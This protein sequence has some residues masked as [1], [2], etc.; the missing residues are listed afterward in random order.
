MLQADELIGRVQAY[1]PTADV[2]L[3]K[4]AYDFSYRDAPGTDCA[5]RGIRTSST[6]ARSPASSPSCR[7]DTASV[8]AGLLHDVVE[9]TLSSVDRRREAVRRRDRHLVDGVTK[10]SQDQLHLEGGPAGRELPQDGRRDGARHPRAPREALRPRRQH[11]DARAH[12]PEAQERIARET[13]EIY[14]PLANRL[15]MQAFKSELE[16][17]S[18]K[19][20][21]PDAFTGVSAG[22]REDE[23]RARQVHRRRLQD[24][25]GT[26]RRAGLRRPTSPAARSTS[27]RSGGR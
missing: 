14:A 9:D 3:I 26:P 5:N 17:L 24:A 1:Q 15:G 2:D 6:R 11:A 25:L 20:L 4:R 22:H 18:F 7:L 19:Y 13:M 12:E 21:E 16:D 8:C 27:T 23:A 10:L